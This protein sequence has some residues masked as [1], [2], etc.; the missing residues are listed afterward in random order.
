MENNKMKALFI[1]TNAGY[2]DGIVKLLRESG[3]KGATILNSR[4]E[5]TM[6]RSFMG[7]AIDSEKE[8]IVCVV[9]E[10]TALKAMKSIKEK[11]GMETTSNSVC[12]TMPIDTLVGMNIPFENPMDEEK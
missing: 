9:D 8:L 3:A 6:H 7:I 12:F 1:I 11:M 10:E 2:A 5:D 4:G